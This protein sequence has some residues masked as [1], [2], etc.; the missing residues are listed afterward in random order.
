MH[1]FGEFLQPHLFCRIPL[2]VTGDFNVHVDVIDNLD[3]IALRELLE[4]VSC[5]QYVDTSTHIHGHTLDLIISR[6]SDDLVVGKPWTDSLISDH[7]SVM[8]SLMT[9]KPPV[10]MKKVVCRKIASINLENF[11]ND[12]RESDLITSTH[13][14]R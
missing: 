14:A 3:A 2:I 12:L 7:M 10:K 9:Q 5:T 11:L 1:K 8:C 4:S 13:N 6:S